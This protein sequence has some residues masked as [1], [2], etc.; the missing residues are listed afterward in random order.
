MV[1]ELTN[2]ASTEEGETRDSVVNGLA[3]VVAS[4]GQN[5]GEGSKSACADLLSEAF[6][7]TN[8]GAFAPF[9]STVL[10]KLTYLH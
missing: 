6:A 5:L 8:K 1:T 9:Y 4:G 10:F 7:E 3:N 2:L